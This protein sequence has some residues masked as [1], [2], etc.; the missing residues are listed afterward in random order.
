MNVQ[1]IATSTR[2]IAGMTNGND[3]TASITPLNT[4]TP[5]QQAYARRLL[6]MDISLNWPRL[7][8]EELSRLKG[9]DEIAKRLIETYNL[10]PGSAR[11]E[12]DVVLRGR[13][14]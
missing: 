7:R 13:D 8:L 5:A 14:F 10:D 1:K 9:R 11:R 6:L 2:E 12:L 3:A 4:M